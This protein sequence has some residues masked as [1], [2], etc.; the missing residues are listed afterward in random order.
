MVTFTMTMIL[1]IST[2]LPVL[3][4]LL[5]EDIEQGIVTG[6]R[7][8]LRFSQSVTQFEWHMKVLENLDSARQARIGRIRT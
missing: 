1:M 5:P 4:E 2:I 7:N 6:K 3:R 8:L